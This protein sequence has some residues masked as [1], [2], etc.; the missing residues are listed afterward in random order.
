MPDVFI[1]YAR[2]T[3]GQKAQQVAEAL[4]A[5]GYD[6]WWDD[7][8]PAHGAFSDVIEERLRAARAV[9]VLWSADARRSHWVRAEAEVARRAGTLVQLT[10][11]G[12]APPLPFSQI[13]C[14]DMT[15][16]SGEA[17]VAGWRKVVASVAILTGGVGLPGAVRPPA[18]TPPAPA[19]P[20]LAVLP[21]DNVSSDL[22]L[23]FFSDG[24]SD[25]IRE[26]IARGAGRAHNALFAAAIARDWD[27]FD[28]VATRARAGGAFD[29]DLA[30]LVRFWTAI[31]TN[32]TPAK[33]RYLGDL[34][35]EFARGRLL[36][37]Y[38]IQNAVTL[39]DLEL[40]FDFVRRYELEAADDDRLPTREFFSFAGAMFMAEN[41]AMIRDPRFA[42]L[43]DR[44]GLGAYWAASGRWPDCARDGVLP[45]DFKGE[46]RRLAA[47]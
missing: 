45:Y 31:R 38:A 23:S 13:Q 9:V 36:Q 27:R 11:D 10:I 32:D 5:L 37:N 21:F 29:D 42:Q 8:L 47:A 7:Q 24:V 44:L 20:L 15:G 1:S 14:A 19:A 6:V 16:W 43:C 35:A 2:S 4:E 28:A 39:G 17:D 34:Q 22:E 12:S 26:T 25:Q 40:A 41:A 30:E 33:Q 3:P 46:C 18:R